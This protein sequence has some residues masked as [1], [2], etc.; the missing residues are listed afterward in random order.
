MIVSRELQILVQ[1]VRQLTRNLIAPMSK[2]EYFF[3][4]I[5]LKG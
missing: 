1:V 2:A 3:A 4:C 5:A